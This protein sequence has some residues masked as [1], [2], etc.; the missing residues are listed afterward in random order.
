MSEGACAQKSGKEGF[1]SQGFHHF[2]PPT[3]KLWVVLVNY[4]FS[5]SL[6]KEKMNE[7]SK[8]QNKLAR[9]KKRH[10]INFKCISR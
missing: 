3:L 7:R 5:E 9:E 4:F 1:V 2:I 6:N 10:S 8:V